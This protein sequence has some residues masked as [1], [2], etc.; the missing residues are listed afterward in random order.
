MRVP[1]C[2]LFH[3]LRSYDNK[4]VEV[5]GAYASDGHGGGLAA[6]CCSGVVLDGYEWRPIFCPVGASA[7]IPLKRS[8]VAFTTDRESVKRFLAFYEE[9]K[10]RNPL[11]D[12]FATFVGEV[13]LKDSYANPLIMPQAGYPY[14]PGFCNQGSYPAA[15]VIKDVRGYREVKRVPHQPACPVEHGPPHDHQR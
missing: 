4:L 7:P 5:E 14:G 11:S 1:I 10:A 6:R 13:Q 9:V 8:E 2:D 3:D 12:V 15:L